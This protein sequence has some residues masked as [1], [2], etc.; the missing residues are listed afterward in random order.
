MA[1]FACPRIVHAP[2]SRQPSYSVEKLQMG[3]SGFQGQAWLG[4]GRSGMDHESVTDGR[5][6]SRHRGAEGQLFR[7]SLTL[8]GRLRWKSTNIVCSTH[9]V[10][11]EDGQVLHVYSECKQICADWLTE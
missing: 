5:L 8:F 10:V 9:R 3:G 7:N 4:R 11:V 1:V 2:L 6:V